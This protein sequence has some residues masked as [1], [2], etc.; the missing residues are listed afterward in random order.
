MSTSQAF[1][2]KWVDKVRNVGVTDLSVALLEAVSPITLIGA[3]LVHMSKPFLHPF[4]PS[5][6]WD[7]LVNLLED[8]QEYQALIQALREESSS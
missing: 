5:A 8:R 2:Q 6:N 1:R 7:G 4:F 3:Q